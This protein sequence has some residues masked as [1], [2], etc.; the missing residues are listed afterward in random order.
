MIDYPFSKE[1]ANVHKETY[2]DRKQKEQGH[3]VI[4]RIKTCVLSGVR[5]HEPRLK[6]ETND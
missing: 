1:P 2:L 5:H 6:V 4:T 3:Y